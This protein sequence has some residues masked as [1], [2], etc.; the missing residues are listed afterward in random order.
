MLRSHAMNQSRTSWPRVVFVCLLLLVALPGGSPARAALPTIRRGRGRALADRPEPASAVNA[1]PHAVDDNLPAFTGSGFQK[2]YVLDNDTDPD[3]DILFLTNA[4][5]PSH[6]N[7]TCCAGS[8][9]FQAIDYIPAPGFVGTDTFSYN[10]TDNHGGH[11]VGVVTVTVAATCVVSGRIAIYAAPYDQLRLTVNP[12]G[13][14]PTGPNAGTCSHA[15][16][17]AIEDGVVE[18]GNSIYSHPFDEGVT[19]FINNTQL[20]PD[21]PMAVTHHSPAPGPAMKGG[22]NGHLSYFRLPSSYTLR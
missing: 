12:N 20:L 18:V 13:G 9:D 7:A 6:G 1:S 8:G 15:P 3:N 21:L 5:S 10:M 2:L 19:F 4:G 17:L 22:L 16:G 14:G 11:D